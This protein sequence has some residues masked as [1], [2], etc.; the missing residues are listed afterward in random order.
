MSDYQ[1][2]IK[3]SFEEFF[4]V[5]FRKKKIVKFGDIGYFFIQEKKARKL[6]NPVDSK[7][8]TTPA[9]S[10]F[11]FMRIDQNDLTEEKIEEMFTEAGLEISE[12]RVAVNREQLLELSSA[13]KVHLY[14]PDDLFIGSFIIKERKA[15]SGINPKTNEKIKIPAEKRILFRST[16][17]VNELVRSKFSAYVRNNSEYDEESGQTKY[18]YE[19]ID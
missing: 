2:Q 8:I 10:F 18:K 15:V 19:K 3:V 6:L 1:V 5:A 12:R 9:S 14:C 7:V 11:Q 16:K 17:N 4:G 13:D